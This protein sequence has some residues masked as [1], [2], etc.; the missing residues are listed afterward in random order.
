MEL[1]HTIMGKRGTLEAGPKEKKKTGGN[2]NTPNKNFAKKRRVKIM[3]GKTSTRLR[4][5]V[6]SEKPP[7]EIGG[8]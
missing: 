8:V 7:P 1:H 4:L 6:M 5:A 2:N 3:Y